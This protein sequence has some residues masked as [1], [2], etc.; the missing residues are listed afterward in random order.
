MNLQNYWQILTGLFEEDD[1]TIQS[2]GYIHHTREIYHDITITLDGIDCCLDWKANP[3][4][5]SARE[6]IYQLIDA[7][8]DSIHLP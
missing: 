8:E 1:L 4:E 7:P 2:E 3:N 6:T 5:W